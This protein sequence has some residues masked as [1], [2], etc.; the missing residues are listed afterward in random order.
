VRAFP[1]LFFLC[2]FFAL[3]TAT[4][5]VHAKPKAGTVFEDGM[6]AYRRGE[7]AEAAEKFYKAYKLRLTRT[8]QR[9]VGLGARGDKATA[10]TAY[11]MVEDD[12]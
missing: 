9:R 11:E 12:D 6:A 4:G 1:P 10:A 5:L 3:S 2:A 8:V 7:F